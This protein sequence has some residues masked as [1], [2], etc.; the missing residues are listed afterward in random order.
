M[1]LTVKSGSRF[2]LDAQLDGNV[3]TFVNLQEGDAYRILSANTADDTNIA[4]WFVLMFVSCSMGFGIYRQ[5]RRRKA[6]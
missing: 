4:I 1:Q 5:Y 2:T 6:F 3:L